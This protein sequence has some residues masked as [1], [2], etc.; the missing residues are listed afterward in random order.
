MEK[1]G[2]QRG[3]GREKEKKGRGK[4]NDRSRKGM[5]GRGNGSERREGVDGKKKSYTCVRCR[6]A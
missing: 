2:M 3:S 4:G 6:K 5:E 1:K